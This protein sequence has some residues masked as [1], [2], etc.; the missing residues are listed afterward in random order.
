MIDERI[1][2]TL[3]ELETNLQNLESA[4]EQV[5]NIVN[6][7][8]GL[9]TATADY[10]E[11]LSVI[12]NRLNRLITVIKENYENNTEAFRRDCE[13]ITTSCNS[14]IQKIDSAV[15]DIKENLSW[16]VERHNKKITF[17][18][19]CNVVILIAIVILILQTN[20]IL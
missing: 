3:S 18:I 20:Y 12:G 14:L 5:R 15:G 19:A 6:S 16:Q 10:V 4:Q 2:R 1:N 11:N 17:V 13:E 8:G 9:R 7:Y